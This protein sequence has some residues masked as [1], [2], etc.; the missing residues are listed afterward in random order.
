MNRDQ[1]LEAAIEAVTALM[2]VCADYHDMRTA[3]IAMECQRA[4]VAERSR[5]QIVHMEHDKGL[6]A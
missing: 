6:R 2:R 3:R 1:T 5:R 4:L